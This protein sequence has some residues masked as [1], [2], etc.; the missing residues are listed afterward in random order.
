MGEI[1]GVGMSH[2][3]GFAAE[4]LTMTRQITGNIARSVERGWADPKWNEPANWPVAV[5]EEYG[6]DEGMSAAIRHRASHLDAVMQARGRHRRVPAGRRPD[7]GRRPVGELPRRHRPALRGLRLGRGAEPPPASPLR[8]RQRLERAGRPRVHVP[9][10]PV[11]GEVPGQQSHGPG[12]RHRLFVPPAPP[13]QAVARVLQHAPVPD[14]DRRGWPYP[15]IP[16]HINCYGDRFVVSHGAGGRSRRVSS[17]T[18]RPRRPSAAS[19]WDRRSRARSGRARGA[20]RSSGR[21]AGRTADSPSGTTTST[22]T[23]RRTG[24]STST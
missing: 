17:R 15:L 23:S 22:R 20:W 7:L 11:E 8:R 1:L 9:G 21:R 10:R 5:L 16:F 24:G 2:Y 18:R 12:V 4:P 13:G 3:P 14:D 6:E 19:R